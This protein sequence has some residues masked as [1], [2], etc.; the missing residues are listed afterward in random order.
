M[1]LTSNKAKAAVLKEE[2]GE[3]FLVLA[4]INH[5]DMEEP[6]YFV[7]NTENI[8]SDG[9]IYSAC[10]FKYTPP[11]FSSEESRPAK[12]T[13]D[14]VDRR[15]MEIIRPINTPF[16]MTFSV[17]LASQPDI[18]EEGPHSFILRNITSN[19]HQVSGDLYDL[20][21]TDRQI[22]AHTYNPF[23]FPGLF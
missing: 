20:Y 7:N 5:P 11:S 14:N 23:D 19:V 6:L 18:I 2:T 9:A 4:K 8:T 15:L 21:L 1:S 22:P 17:V 10:A 16:T 12:I 13:I 3:V